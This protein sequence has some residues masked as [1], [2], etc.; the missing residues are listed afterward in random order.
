MNN[1]SAA[2]ATGPDFMQALRRD[3]AGLSRVL[4]EV[5]SQAA[6]LT[7]DPDTVR[8]VLVDALRYLL[9]YHHAF[10]HPREDRL[11]ARIRARDDSL[12]DSLGEL[13]HEHEV[14]EQQLS[15]LAEALDHSS[16]SQLRGKAGH[17]LAGRI[18]DYVR[19]TRTHM[20]SEEAVFYTRAEGVLDDRDWK[21]VIAA[22]DGRQDPMADLVE[23]S[24]S[25]P[26]LAE[27]LGLPVHYLGLIEYASPLREEL[28]AQMLALVDVYG[29]LAFDAMNLGRGHVEKLLAVR[30]PVSLMQAVGSISSANL[31]FAGQCLIRPPRWALNSAASML[32]VG[33][34]P[35]LRGRE[36]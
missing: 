5:D 15:D 8:P 25:Y 20:R 1:K 3:H 7:R 31:H 24:E 34:R 11:F 19:H 29:G 4:R 6:R 33:L 32:V 10:H 12:D 28:R 2:L 17:R 30:G 13:S 35:Y 22:D 21:A 27:Q 9:R 23:M 26:N 18:Q 14:G 16:L 36:S